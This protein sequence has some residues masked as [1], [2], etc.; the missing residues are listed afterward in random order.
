MELDKFGRPYPPKQGGYYVPS[1][2]TDA[3][4]V[5]GSQILLITRGKEPFVGRLAFPGGHLDYNED[6]KDCVLRE[7]KEEAG[8]DGTVIRLVTVRGDPARDPRKHMIGFVYEVSIP[9]DAVVAAGD[10]AA[11]AQFYDIQTVLENPDNW[12]FDHHSIL[13]EFL[14]QRASL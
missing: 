9:E 11:T 3:V 5:K 12:A 13:Q 6:P 7:L 4:V 14:S 2:G 10:D 8:V 1:S